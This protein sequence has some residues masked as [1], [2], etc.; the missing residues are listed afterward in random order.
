MRLLL[1]SNILLAIAWREPSRYGEAVDRLLNSA[2][3][4]K[5]ASVASIWEIA[6]KHRLGKLTL[7]GR[8]EDFP[9]FLQSLGCELLVVDHRHAVEDLVNQPD[10]KDPFDRLLLA[11]C[12]I[13]GMRLVTTD[14]VLVRHPLAWRPA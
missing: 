7:D 12:Q 2:S 1:D 10:T 3:H 5:I 13:E 14:R 8:I 4:D 6:I 11:Q 9:R